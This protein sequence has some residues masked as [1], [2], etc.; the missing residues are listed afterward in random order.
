[1]EYLQVYSFA[2]L[3]GAFLNTG[4]NKKI[5]VTSLKRFWRISADLPALSFNVLDGILFPVVAFLDQFLKVH[6]WYHS[7]Q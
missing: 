4:V 3:K 1:M 2:L 6:S 7:C 5:N